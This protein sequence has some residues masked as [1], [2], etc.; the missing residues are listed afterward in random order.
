MENMFTH[1]GLS[2]DPARADFKQKYSIMQEANSNAGVFHFEMNPFI[3]MTIILK[4]KLISEETCMILRNAMLVFSHSLAS[5]LLTIH[6]D[7]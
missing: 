1:N 5:A 7:F 2:H 6:L 3:Q 4:K